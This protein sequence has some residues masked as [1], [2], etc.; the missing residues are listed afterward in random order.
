MKAVA[1][2]TVAVLRGTTTDDYGDVVDGST[3]ISTGV[4]A[5]ILEQR[6]FVATEA[7]PTPRAVI[8]YTG[9]VSA[10]T[11]IRDSDRIRDERTSAVYIV[12]SAHQVANPAMTNDL[13]LDLR[14]VA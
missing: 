6:R 4:P 11:D 13:R 7:D 5:S 9:R 2:T 12:D 3:A 14:R 8:T 1:T 10:G